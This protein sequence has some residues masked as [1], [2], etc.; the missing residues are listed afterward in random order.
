MLKIEHPG[1]FHDV[2][3]TVRSLCVMFDVESYNSS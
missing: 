2:V 1:D 3:A